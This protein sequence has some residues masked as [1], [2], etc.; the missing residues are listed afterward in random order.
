MVYINESISRLW[1]ERPRVSAAKTGLASGCKTLASGNSYARRLQRT[2]G[3]IS[4]TDLT[5]LLQK[6]S[7]SAYAIAAASL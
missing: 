1:T 3:A 7:S 6:R 2:R 4:A 5:E